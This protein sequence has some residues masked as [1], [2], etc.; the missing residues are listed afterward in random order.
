MWLSKLIPNNIDIS[1][2]KEILR[3]IAHTEGRYKHKDEINKKMFESAWI[4][5]NEPIIK[6]FDPKASP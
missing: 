4:V 2:L 3:W 5:R 6:L 1:R